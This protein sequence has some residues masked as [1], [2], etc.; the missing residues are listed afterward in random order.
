MAVNKVER[1]IAVLMPSD[2]ITNRGVNRILQDN[3]L[4]LS[5]IH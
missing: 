2:L 4:N 1:L 3:D 5:L